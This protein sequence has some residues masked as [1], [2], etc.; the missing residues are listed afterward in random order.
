MG[1]RAIVGALGVLG[2][3]PTVI[4]FW[5]KW[6]GNCRELAPALHA[7]ADAY[8][9]RVTFVTVAADVD[10][11]PDDVKQFAHDAAVRKALE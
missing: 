11:T 1:I 8:V 5:A 7:A 9:G 4:E 10:E 6:C 3:T 2:H